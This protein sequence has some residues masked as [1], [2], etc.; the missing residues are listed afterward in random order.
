[1]QVLVTGG[2]GYIGSHIVLELLNQNYQVIV[3]DNL[4]NCSIE[5][6]GKI[7]KNVLLDIN[8]DNLYFYQLDMLDIDLLDNI[9]SK[10]T[11]S[12]II[13]L[14]GL[15]SVG[16]SIREPEKYYRNNI[17]TT[18]NLITCMKKYSVVNLIFSSSA[19]VYGNI[20]KSPLKEDDIV[21]LGLTNPYGK[22][23]YFQEE[24]LSDLVKSDSK[25]KVIL[26]RYFNPIGHINLDFKE[27]P[28]GTPNNLFPYVVKVHTSELNKLT[29][30]GSD[31]DT[32]DGTCI[33]DFIH[34]QD[35]ADSHIE[36][37]KYLID[38]KD[39][40]FEIYNVGT[41][42]GTTV[43]ELINSYE[44]VNNIKINWEFGKRRDGDIDVVYANVDKVYK[45]IGWKSKYSLET[46]V[47]YN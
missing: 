4:S 37:I 26:L 28:N 43:L 2:L 27:E 20:N 30:Y 9:F 3:I 16:E 46:M 5:K 41:G 39:S 42:N 40:M 34:V 32:R 22:T 33:R 25:F 44:K 24:I 21:G 15:K 11:I 10:H 35:L 7:K 1:M 38:C 12:G 19:T 8:R 29:I 45:K 36:C 31:Y 17:V 47:K 14:A 6:L 18:L 23:K 13:H